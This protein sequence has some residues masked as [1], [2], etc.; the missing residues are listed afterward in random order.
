MSCSQTPVARTNLLPSSNLDRSRRD[1]GVAGAVAAAAAG[2]T[3]G[4]SRRDSRVV[5]G[6]MGWRRRRGRIGEAQTLRSDNPSNQP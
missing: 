2:T 4:L 5:G 1:R 3:L 6:H